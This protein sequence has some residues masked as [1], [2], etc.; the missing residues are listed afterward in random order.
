MLVSGCPCQNVDDT[1]CLRM[2]LLRNP[3]EDSIRLLAP[4]LRSLMIPESVAEEAL[5]AP[6]LVPAE[7]MAMWSN[8]HLV[9]D[10]QDRIFVW[11]GM[12]AAA[13]LKP[14]GPG[15]VLMFAL[16]PAP[17]LLA[18]RGRLLPR[19]LHGRSAGRCHQSLPR[20]DDSADQGLH[21]GLSPHP[22]LTELLDIGWQEGSSMAR[23]LF[24]RLAPSHKAPDRDQIA[25]FPLLTSLSDDQRSEIRSKIPTTDEPSLQEYIMRVIMR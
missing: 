12:H 6:Q 21:H 16:S 24:C 14:R 25:N 3:V 5:P 18:A 4:E 9:L 13:G 10:C 23:Y 2:L 8:A 15:S 17:A 7:T 19:E 22:V 20:R 1:Y 11:S